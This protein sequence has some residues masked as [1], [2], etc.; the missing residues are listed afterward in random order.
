M[1]R[2]AGPAPPSDPAAAPGGVP[3]GVTVGATAGVAA[4]REGAVSGGAGASGAA[5]GPLPRGGGGGGRGRRV[6]TELHPRV[7]DLVATRQKPVVKRAG[8]DRDGPTC[9][10]L[11]EER[12]D[13]VELGVG[14]LALDPERQ[15]MIRLCARDAGDRVA[16]RARDA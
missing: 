2:G 9:A 13:L 3:R 6:A 16:N 12:L 10:V 11:A 8:Q 7:V 4:A 1:F 14:R 15:H 5:R